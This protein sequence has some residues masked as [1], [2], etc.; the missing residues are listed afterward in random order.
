MSSW[1][2]GGCWAHSCWAELV[3]EW[4]SLHRP[5]CIPADPLSSCPSGSYRV[6]PRGSF[7]AFCPRGKSASRTARAQSW[8]WRHSAPPPPP[9]GSHSW[10]RDSASHGR[11]GWRRGSGWGNLGICRGKKRD[12]AGGG[13]GAL[14]PTRHRCP[15]PSNW[16][17]WVLGRPQGRWWLSGCWDT[18]PHETLKPE[19][20]RRVRQRYLNFSHTDSAWIDR[21]WWIFSFGSSFCQSKLRQDITL[22]SRKLRWTFFNVV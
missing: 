14:G 8:W 15:C 11:R 6:S 7:Y 13:R 17:W 19:G 16:K 4:W 22:A 12:P 2:S 10:R 9:A 3:T 5:G 18:R 1:F 20:K 21:K